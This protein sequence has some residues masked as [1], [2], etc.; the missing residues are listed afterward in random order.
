[1][2]TQRI[3]G[4]AQSPQQGLLVMFERLSG[5]PG[6]AHAGGGTIDVPTAMDLV[7]CE[8]ICNQAAFNRV[9]D[10]GTPQNYPQRYHDYGSNDSR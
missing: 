5:C 4:H 6:C 9:C 3:G 7:A 2:P 10:G 1:M 8:V